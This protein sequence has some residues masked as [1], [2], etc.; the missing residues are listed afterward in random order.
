MN[1]SFF[2]N[3]SSQMQKRDETLR[4]YYGEKL[5]PSE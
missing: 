2:L 3:P 4:A 5:T 1:T